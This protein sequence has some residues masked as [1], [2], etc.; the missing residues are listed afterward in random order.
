MRPEERTSLSPHLCCVLCNRGDETGITGP[1]SC[2]QNVAAHQNCLLFASGIYC[3]S[4]P[5]FD[6]LFGFDVEDVRNECRR[7]RKLKCSYCKKSGATAGCEVKS[8]KRSYHYPCIQKARAI[9]AENQSEGIYTLYCEKHNQGTNNVGD[10]K[11]LPFSSPDTSEQENSRGGSEPNWTSP[12]EPSCS[13]VLSSTKLQNPLDL[14]FPLNDCETPKRRSPNR[15]R[16]HLTYFSDSDETQ[17]IMT[18]LEL[19][20][21][22]RQ[23]QNKE[24]TPDSEN[25]RRDCKEPRQEVARAPNGDEAEDEAKSDSDLDSP[26]LLPPEFRHDNIPFTVIADSG[27]SI[28]SVTENSPDPCSP[29]APREGETP[30]RKLD[31]SVCGKAIDKITEQPNLPVLS[32]PPPF[33]I[34]KSFTVIKKE[35]FDIEEKRCS[36]RNVPPLQIADKLPGSH[37]HPLDLTAPA[38]CSTAQV[39]VTQPV[40][41][42]D[43][44]DMSASIFWRR[45][46]EM[47][48]TEGIFTELTRQLTSLAEKVQNQHATQQDYAVSLRILQASG[49]LPAI[50]KQL[51][52]DLNDQERELQKK[53]EALR[54]AKTVLEENN[55]I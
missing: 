16:K 1:L 39:Q 33:I 45:C 41:R 34:G 6:D 9:P 55:L 2:K 49:R 19:E 17:D 12:V 47:G 38:G 13:M 35:L 22:T 50:Y 8:C 52:Q 23:M 27:P 46:N 40:G 15:K 4:S 10:P 25:R 3:K 21:N 18:P 53:K 24:P 5:T 42:A 51:E 29:D 48:C 54:D 43:V 28:E 37:D 20:D 26:S 11:V 7:G 31:Q 14:L 36:S 44:S 32:S 30:L